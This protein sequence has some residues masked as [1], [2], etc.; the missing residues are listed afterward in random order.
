MFS[1]EGLKEDV[2][3]SGEEGVVDGRG[4]RMEGLV[5]EGVTGGVA[6]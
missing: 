4:R 3:E 5:V 1:G 2:V 6:Y